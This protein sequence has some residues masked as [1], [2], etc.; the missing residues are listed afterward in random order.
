M[1]VRDSLSPLRAPSDI[2]TLRSVPDMD[3]DTKKRLEMN[4][5]TMS[6]MT[7]LKNQLQSLSMKKDKVLLALFSYRDMY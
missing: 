6:K 3:E 4:A 2:V 7:N 5:V 1:K